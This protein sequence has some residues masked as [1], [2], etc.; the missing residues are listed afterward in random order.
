[1]HVRRSRQMHDTKF[2][3]K[4]QAANQLAGVGVPLAEPPVVSELFPEF[5]PFAMALEPEI[6]IVNFIWHF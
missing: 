2:D 3:G 1:M 6:S 5:V 4:N